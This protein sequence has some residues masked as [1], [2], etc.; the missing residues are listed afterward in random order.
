MMN[1]KTIAE[2]CVLLITA[3]FTTGMA[4]TIFKRREILPD[5]WSR[6]LWLIGLISAIL[7]LN[8]PLATVIMAILL[9]FSIVGG[10]LMSDDAKEFRL[11]IGLGKVLGITPALG[12]VINVIVGCITYFNKGKHLYWLIAPALF[13][14]ILSIAGRE[15]GKK[16][17]EKEKPEKKERN[18]DYVPQAILCVAL[19]GAIVA[20]SAFIIRIKGVI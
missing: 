13:Y 2:L 20:V 14:L 6:I 10:L 9:I 5:G 19:V 11:A 15:S 1:W 18:F 3:F 12:I 4:I 8:N 7:C 16:K 17:E